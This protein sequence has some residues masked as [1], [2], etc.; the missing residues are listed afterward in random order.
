MIISII[1]YGPSSLK[2]TTGLGLDWIGLITIFPPRLLLIL[3]I[4]V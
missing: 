4:R 1:I 3:L 2:Y